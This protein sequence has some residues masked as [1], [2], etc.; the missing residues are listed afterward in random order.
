MSKIV[1]KHYSE[2]LK[3]DCR[4]RLEIIKVVEAS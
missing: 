4:W 1:A 3:R 2:P